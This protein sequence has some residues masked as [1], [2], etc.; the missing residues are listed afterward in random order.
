MTANSQREYRFERKFLVEGLLPQQAVGLIKRHPYMFFQP[1]PPR[2]INNF[3]LD[4]PEMDN[5]LDNVGGA[6]NRRKVRL[7]WYG[8]L[9]GPITASTLE[10]KIKRGLVGTKRSYPFGAFELHPDYDAGELR[11]SARHSTMP[12]EI[13]TVVLTQN[14]VLLNC[15]YRHYFATRDNR[16]RLTVDT[17]LTYYR[18]GRLANQFVHH[19]RD[20]RSIIVELKYDQQ[21]DLE[22]QRISGF[23]PFRVTKSSKYVMGIDRVYF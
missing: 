6:P 15:Y 23:F 8:P 20:H 14:I 5:Y 12:E 16:F 17:D 11:K 18:V 10:F 3:Y 9:F 1:Y 22:A 2:Q 19:Q 13:K 21:L 4:T 7:R